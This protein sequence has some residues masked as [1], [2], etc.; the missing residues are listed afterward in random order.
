MRTWWIRI[1]DSWGYECRSEISICAVPFEKKTINDMKILVKLLVIEILNNVIQNPYG[2]ISKF[3]NSIIRL[4]VYVT[5]MKHLHTRSNIRS[6]FLIL[7]NICL[8][9]PFEQFETW[10]WIFVNFDYYL[11]MKMNSRTPICVYSCNRC[12]PLL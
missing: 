1:F 7:R 11:E 2:V 9:I 4:K 3:K 5:V 6:S 8:I 12:S 10:E